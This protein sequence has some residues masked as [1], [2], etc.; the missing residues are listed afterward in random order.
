MA[1]RQYNIKKFFRAAPNAPLARY[2]KKHNALGDFD[3]KNLKEGTLDSLVAAWL[4]LPDRQRAK[5]EAEF[6]DIY[7]LSCQ[8][9]VKA[10]MDEARYWIVTVDGEPFEPFMDWLAGL[11]NDAD[12]AFQTFMKHPKY[13]KGATNF[14]HADSLSWWRKRKGLPKVAAQ[15]DDASLDELSDKIIKYFTTRKARAP[16]ARWSPFAAT[17]STIS[18]PTPRTIPSGA[19]NG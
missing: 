12:R 3:F 14:F 16:T 6:Q 7:A 10:I 15:C 13:W 2:F 4:E 9:G 19:L 18:S 17:I 8:P 1:A 11:K 5:M